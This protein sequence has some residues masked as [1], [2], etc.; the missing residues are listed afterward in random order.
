M[1][2]PTPR[3]YVAAG[4]VAL[5][6][7]EVVALPFAYLTRNGLTDPRMEGW[8]WVLLWAL[9]PLAV[10]AAVWGLTAAILLVVWVYEKAAPAPPSE[11]ELE[12]RRLRRQAL[13]ELDRMEKLP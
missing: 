6:L 10:G 9:L 12:L 13:E 3:Q 7:Y 2:A 8:P 5:V 4:L 1:S 11:D